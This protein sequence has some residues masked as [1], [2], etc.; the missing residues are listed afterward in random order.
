MSKINKS[1]EEI[2]ADYYEHLNHPLLDTI[3]YLREVILY[4]D[5]SIGEI[6]K[7]NS[8]CFYY[9]GEIKPFNPKEYKRDIVVF[10]L[11]KKDIILLIFPTGSIINDIHNVFNGIYPDTRKS[12][13]FKSIEEVKVK[14]TD[15]KIVIQQWLGLIDK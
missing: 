12:L 4:V 11:H 7:W 14:E 13:S 15:L 9:T 2:L 3:Q 8:P 6:V 1:D 10:N 5:S